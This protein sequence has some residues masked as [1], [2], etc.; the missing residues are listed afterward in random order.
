[1]PLSES[2]D[3]FVKT[4]KGDRA[5]EVCAKLVIIEVILKLESGSYIK[6]DTSNIYNR[7]IFK[8]KTLEETWCRNFLKLITPFDKE[9]DQ[10]KNRL[11]SI[12][13]IIFNYDR[14]VEHYLYYA[15]MTY[16]DFS[17]DQSAGLVNS[18]TIIHPYGKVGDMLWENPRSL[19]SYKIDFGSEISEGSLLDMMG[20]I[21]TFSEGTDP[22]TSNIGQVK[23]LMT[24]ANMIIFLGF[25]YM[26][27]NLELLAPSPEELKRPR[28]VKCYGSAYDISDSNTEQIKVKLHTHFKLR[29]EDIILENKFKCHKLLADYEQLIFR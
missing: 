24:N 6:V 12:A 15:L 29:N 13:L 8:K 1:M 21:K 19:N 5:I 3:N 2:I 4:H 22:T 26:D 25:S 14:C 9:F 28:K 16:F 20:N 23:Y 11:E 27:I 17:H 10:V 7:I 18:M